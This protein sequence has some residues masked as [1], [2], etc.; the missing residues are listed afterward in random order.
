[1]WTIRE[2]VMAFVEKQQMIQPG[3][4]LVAGISGGADSV[5][6]FLLLEEMKKKLNFDFLVVHVNHQLRGEEAK[7]DQEFVRKLCI[8]KQI[9]I[10]VVEKDVKGMAEKGGISLEE[11]GRNAR[12]DAFEQIKEQMGADKIVL[13]HHQDDVAETM[14]HHLARGTGAAG[15]CSL[16][17]VAGDRI[18]P[19]L[20]VSRGE[21]EQWLYTQGQ[22]WQTDSTNLED[23]YTRNKIRHHVVE[24]L[25]KE[26]NPRTSAHMASVALELEMMEDF[27]ARETKKRAEKYVEKESKGYRIRQEIVEEP[28]LIQKRILME[29][30]R[31]ASGAW[32]DL[33]RCHIDDLAELFDRSV[34]KQIFLPY[35]MR[36][37]R[38]YDGVFL[39]KRVRKE[40]KR[41]EM[42]EATSLFIPGITRMGNYEI[43]CRVIPKNFQGIQEKKYTKW[44]DYDKIKNNVEIRHRRPGDRI[45]VHVSGGSKKLKDFLIDRK[46][47]QK[48]RDGLWLLAEDQEILWVIG[49]RIS[50][51]YKVTET[52]KNILYVEIRGGEFHERQNQCFN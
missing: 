31:E 1:M 45:C 25:Q 16:R 24:Y 36:A 51:K 33:T 22:Q 47:P 19:L 39:E 11:A 5:C 15:L 37:V 23:A 12:Y 30:L 9:P 8:Q 13:A 20:C 32:R 27:V 42:T 44:L 50:Q 29:T 28:L 2:K 34:G 52:T 21:I 38:E 48:T 43:I 14:I 17:P 35:H 6:L 41:Q 40:E 49:D 18:R 46:I 26:I 7:R 4:L 3:E 10:Y